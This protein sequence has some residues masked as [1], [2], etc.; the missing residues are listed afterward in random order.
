MKFNIEV[1][2]EDRWVNDFCSFL[3]LLEGYGKIGHSAI[4][5]FLLMVMGSLDLNSI[6]T[7]IFN[8]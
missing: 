4:I 8:M 3:K 2:M 5:G 6:L 1:E 7:Q